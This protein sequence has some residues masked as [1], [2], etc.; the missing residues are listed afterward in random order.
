MGQTATSHLVDSFDPVRAFDASNQNFMNVQ[1]SNQPYS[2]LQSPF[3]TKSIQ[4]VQNFDAN[5]IID[6]SDSKPIHNKKKS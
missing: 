5:S 4:Q 2:N 6:T 3:A 1:Y